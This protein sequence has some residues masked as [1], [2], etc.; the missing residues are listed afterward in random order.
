[1]FHFVS[2]NP[3]NTPLCDGC[4]VAITVTSQ[5]PLR[6]LRRPYAKVGIKGRDLVDLDG[7]ELVVDHPTNRVGRWI[8]PRLDEVD[9]PYLIIPL[10][11]HWGFCY[12]LMIHQV[13]IRISELT[14]W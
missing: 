7:V 6:P 13:W 3:F 14:L 12:L 4:H 8:I 9:E 5:S 10:I 1:M 11:Y 2:V